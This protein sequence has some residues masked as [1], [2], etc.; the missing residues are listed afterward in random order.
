MNST[1]IRHSIVIKG[2]VVILCIAL[3]L[4]VLLVFSSVAGAHSAHS[5]IMLIAPPYQVV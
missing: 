2:V 5:G 4:A 3:L 1:L